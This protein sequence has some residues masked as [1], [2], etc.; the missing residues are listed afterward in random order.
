MWHLLVDVAGSAI[1]PTAADVVA[2]ELLHGSDNYGNSPVVAGRSTR[3]CIAPR[4]AVI[5]AEDRRIRR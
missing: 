5:A 1:S 4:R 3:S 2:V